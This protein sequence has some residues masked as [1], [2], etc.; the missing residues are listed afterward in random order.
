MGGAI[1]Q[2]QQ[3]LWARA[4]RMVGGA[5]YVHKLEFFVKHVRV[6]LQYNFVLINKGRIDMITINK[7]ILLMV[8]RVDSN[9]DSVT[10]YIL[11]LGCYCS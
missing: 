1:L 7:V 3:L 9:H 8:F 10:R 5:H 2:P 4:N 11:S 6:F